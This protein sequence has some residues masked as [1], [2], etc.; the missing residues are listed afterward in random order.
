MPLYQAL[1]DNLDCRLSSYKMEE[2]I[3]FSFLTGCPA[4]TEQGSCGLP[5]VAESQQLQFKGKKKKG[6]KLNHFLA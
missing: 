5:R 3:I 6:G 2:E 4:G 1:L